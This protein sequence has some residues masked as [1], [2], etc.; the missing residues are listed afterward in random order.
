MIYGVLFYRF[1]LIGLLAIG[2]GATTIPFLF[3]L[4]TKH[5]W[6]TSSELINM[7][8]VSESTPGP[9]GIN[10]ATFAGFKAAGIFGGITATFGIITP[11]LIIIILLSKLLNR[12]A[13]HAK[14]DDF[15]KTIQPAVLALILNATVEITKLGVQ[16]MISVFILTVLLFCMFYFKRSPIFYILLSGVIGY[17]LQL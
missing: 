14:A 1:F 5:D 9:V 8:A 7:I 4:C 3:D 10:M 16:N 2:G 15:F 17:C 12:F 6:F 11:S 13:C